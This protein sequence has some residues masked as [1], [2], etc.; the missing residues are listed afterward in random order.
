MKMQTSLVTRTKILN[1]KALIFISKGNEN[2]DE[3]RHPLHKKKS[4]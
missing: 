3:P 1:V 4:L 2:A